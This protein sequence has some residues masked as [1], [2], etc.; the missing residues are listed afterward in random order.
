MQHLGVRTRHTF[1]MEAPGVA[2]G[3]ARPAAETPATRPDVDL[4]DSRFPAVRERLIAICRSVAGDGAEDAVQE[5]YLTARKRISQL[6]DVG[7]LEGWL[8]TIAIRHCIDRHRRDRRFRD[9]LPMLFQSQRRITTESDPALTEL[10]DRLPV[11]QRA[12][13]VLHYGHGYSLPEL[14]DLLG[15][16]HTN[17]RTIILRARRRLYA[18][19]QEANRD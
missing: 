8:T 5:T 15:L 13:I 10:I 3:Q 6:R 2:V 17:V 11:R 16:S 18:A 12:V 4:L 14:A 9:R 19:W 7:A 1:E